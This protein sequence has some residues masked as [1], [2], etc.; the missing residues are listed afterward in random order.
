M[1]YKV[2]V[3]K[4]DKRSKSREGV[5]SWKA[6]GV[7]EMSQANRLA[8]GGGAGGAERAELRRPHGLH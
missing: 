2:A 7:R 6:A 1:F 5:D 4:P 3:L 8:L